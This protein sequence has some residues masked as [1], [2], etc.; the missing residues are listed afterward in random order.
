MPLQVS[1]EAKARATWPSGSSAERGA[2]SLHGWP[3]A[4]AVRGPISAMNSS[5]SSV[6]RP[7][8]SICQTKRSGWRRSRRRSQRRLPWR[9]IGFAATGRPAFRH[10]VLRR[11]R[12]GGARTGGAAG[13]GAAAGRRRRRSA[14]ILQLAWRRRARRPVSR[15]A[16]ASPAARS[17]HRRRCARAR[18]CRRHRS[19]S[20]WPCRPAPW[21][22]AA[23][24]RARRAMWRGRARSA[25]P[26]S[27]AAARRRPRTARAAS[28]QPASSRC[29]CS[30][31]ESRGPA[32]SVA[33]TRMAG[34]RSAS[35]I[36]E[37]V[38]I[39]APPKRPPKPRSRS[40]RGAAPC[41][42]VPASRA[43]C[44]AAEPLGSMVWPVS[45]AD[46]AA[47]KI[48]AAAGLPHRMRVAS[49]LH[50]HAGMSPVAY[51]ARR[52]SLRKPR[53]DP[54]SLIH[55]LPPQPISSVCRI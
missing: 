51:G 3:S 38:H 50:S 19:P 46:D 35:M 13:C 4:A 23:S 5:E 39:S 31:S 34:V 45:A 37:Q 1:R 28:S 54:C 52:G 24:R 21:R 55:A 40:S 29:A 9:A 22:R 41:G 43:I 18:S 36:R 12:G 7:S 53:R 14:V 49:A 11:R 32:A 33:T 15:R 20:A 44:S 16:K 2:I 6:K 30:A 47:L 26:A 17:M 27:R 42:S 10:S 8:A 25:P 48:A